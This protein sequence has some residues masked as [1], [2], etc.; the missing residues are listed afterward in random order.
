MHQNIYQSNHF[1]RQV[2]DS[3]INRHSKLNGD[4]ML[5]ALLKND[6]RVLDVG[7]GTGTSAFSIA[8]L[9]NGG[10]IVGV[11]ISA[12][13][14]C[15]ANNEA[16]KKRIANIHFIQ[17]DAAD[18][19]FACSIFDIV[20]CRRLLMHIEKC[21][22]AIQE[23]K[24]VVEKGGWVVAFEG[25]FETY[26]YYPVFK[27]WELFMKFVQNYIATANIGRQLWRL[28]HETGFS[29]IAIRKIPDVATG[30][31][32]K[33]NVMSWLKALEGYSEFLVETKISDKRTIS[34][35]LSE[36][37]QLYDS[38]NGSFFSV[39]YEIRGKK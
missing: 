6:S 25:D 39:E 9:I 7:C 17:S 11:D 10:H 23:F 30:S 37:Y 19:P 38:P 20:Y 18:L 2:H 36:G 31:A 26:K 1:M 12:E 3:I 8:D 35:I 22:E 34:S 32:F 27:G 15:N 21:P 16:K 28:F 14:I 5:L 33:Q 29:E 4:E 13:T 24:R